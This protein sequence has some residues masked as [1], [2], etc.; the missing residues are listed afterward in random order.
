MITSTQNAQVKRIIQLKQK[1][2]A[3]HEEGLFVS[4]GV[5]IFAEAP[6]S[7]IEKVYLSES[8]GG[9]ASLAEKLSRLPCERVSDSVFA[10]MSDTVSP[11][12]V[13]ALL[14]MPAYQAGEI[15]SGLRERKRA[16]LVVVLENLQDPGN[17]GTILRTGEGAGADLILLTE[18]SVDITSPKVIRS[19]MGSIFRVPFVYTRDI[20]DAVRILR[21]AGIK[22]YAAH[23]SGKKAYTQVSYLEGSAFLI[24][25]EGN[26]LT[27][28]AAAACDELIRIPMMG[29]VE[30]LNAAMAAGIL[31]YEAM[32]QRGEG[33]F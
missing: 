33:F 21:D 16:P 10:K 9:E 13:L 25:N 4:E 18:N 27:K 1:T 6:P 31:M 5:R 26:G 14:R 17:L 15:L 3:R 22:S 19:T 20:S 29:Q 23:L 7:W 8:F 30:S 28:E 2:K 12:G 11:Q 32:R 24:G